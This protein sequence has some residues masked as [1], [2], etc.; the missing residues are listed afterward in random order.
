MG[1]EGDGVVVSHASHGFAGLR[2]FWS[3]SSSGVEQKA[4]PPC[5]GTPRGP[6]E[7]ER[8]RRRV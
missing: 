4:L 3:P 2:P 6:E 1:Y 8:T 7:R 5:R